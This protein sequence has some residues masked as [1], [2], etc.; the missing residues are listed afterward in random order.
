MSTFGWRD[1]SRISSAPTYPVAPMIPTRSLRG[2]PSAGI[3]RSERGKMA[4][5]SV[6]GVVAIV[7]AVVM[8]A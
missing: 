8:G 2:P 7:S 6:V 3:P 1:N 5:D 4:V